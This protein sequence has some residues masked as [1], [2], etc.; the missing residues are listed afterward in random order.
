MVEKARPNHFYSAFTCMLH[1]LQFSYARFD[2][3]RAN[4][5]KSDDYDDPPE[6]AFSHTDTKFMPLSRN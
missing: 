4:S 2:S 1:S 3:T 5:G 6:T